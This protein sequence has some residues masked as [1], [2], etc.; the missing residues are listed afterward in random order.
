MKSLIKRLQFF[1][2]LYNLEKFKSFLKKIRIS[3]TDSKSLKNLRIENLI[4]KFKSFS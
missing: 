1:N 4:M 3:N 2:I